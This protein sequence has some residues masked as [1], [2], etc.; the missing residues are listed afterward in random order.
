MEV[1]GT[2]RFKKR[3]GGFMDK[4]DTKGNWTGVALSRS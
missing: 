4:T 1:D 3:L 2:S